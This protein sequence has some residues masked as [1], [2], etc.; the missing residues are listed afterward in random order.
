[1]GSKPP[2]QKE[3][4]IDDKSEKNDIEGRDDPKMDDNMDKSDKQEKP[5]TSQVKKPYFSPIIAV[6]SKTKGILKWLV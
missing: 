5:V 4:I 2:K 1:M 6:R 3:L